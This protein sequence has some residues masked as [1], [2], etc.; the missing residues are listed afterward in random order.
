MDINEKMKLHQWAID[1]NDQKESGL[2][3][4]DW[5]RMRNLPISTFRFRCRKVKIAMEK[6]LDENKGNANLVLAQKTD[7]SCANS[8]PVFAKVNLQ[9]SKDVSSGISIKLANAE[10]TIAPDTPAEHI[11]M[12]LEALAY[13]Q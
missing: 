11:R 1:M 2:S 6:Q 10:L 12:V 4:K 5:C 8:E 13:A 7:L 3:Q 9:T